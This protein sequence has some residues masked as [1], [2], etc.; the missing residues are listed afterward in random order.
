M[1]TSY[2]DR[3]ARFLNQRGFS[4]LELLIS[5][6]LLAGVVVGLLRAF[7][8]AQ[9]FTPAQVA[10]SN[11]A[12][13]I[14]EKLEAAHEAI[15]MDWWDDASGNDM[16]PGLHDQQVG[17]KGLKWTVTSMNPAGGDPDEDFRKVEITHT[18]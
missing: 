15:R 14:N 16:T 13:A 10:R 4:L 2:S 11:Q 3:H 12:Y 8:S 9:S 17:G 1:E 6:V 5:G 7:T 18:S